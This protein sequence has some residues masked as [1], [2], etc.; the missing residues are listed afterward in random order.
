MTN[1]NSPYTPVPP[2]DPYAGGPPQPYLEP[3]FPHAAS[4]QAAY[5][6][7]PW[8][9]PSY[10]AYGYGYGQPPMAPAKRTPSWIIWLIV[11]CVAAPILLAVG[12]YAFVAKTSSDLGSTLESMS[13]GQT[14]Q[15]L[16]EDL[17]V[18]LGAFDMD[19]SEYSSRG[20][21]PVTVKNKGDK[22]ATF[23][24]RIEAVTDSG[25]RITDASVFANDLG[26]GQSYT[27]DLSFFV[28]DDKKR[29]L[30]HATFHIVSVSKF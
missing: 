20:T 17:D 7:Q 16:D 4:G 28:D 11:A 6:Q 27:D 19:T 14:Q 21:L 26:P 18:T 5:G 12:A 3:S 9:P 13:G 1:S 29:D 22:R 24:V 23:T 2:T 30:S 25:E 8:A 15:I 10:P